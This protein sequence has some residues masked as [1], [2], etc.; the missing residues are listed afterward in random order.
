MRK[1]QE[2]LSKERDASQQLK[3]NLELAIKISNAALIECRTV[4]DIITG[5]ERDKF[6]PK[7]LEMMP[8][9]E[10]ALE[11]L[12]DCEMTRENQ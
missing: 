10:V 2:E 6:F 9:K 8:K 11:K 1:E 7:L 5:E 3:G 12:I 4:A